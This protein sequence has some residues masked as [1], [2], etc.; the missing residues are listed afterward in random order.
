MGVLW[1]CSGSD[2]A[3]TAVG[4]GL[5]SVGKLKIPQDV[6]STPGVKKSMKLLL[7]WVPEPNWS[8]CQTNK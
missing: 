5:I 6:P 2:S 4:V 1:Q 7:W 3:L 8:K